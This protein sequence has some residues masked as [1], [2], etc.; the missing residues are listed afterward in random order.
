MSPLRPIRAISASAFR[1]GLDVTARRSSPLVT[2][3]RFSPIR[4]TTSAMVPR[5]TISRRSTQSGSP[6]RS[7][8]AW[9]SLKATPTPARFW[10]GYAASRRLGLTTATAEGRTSGTS[11]WSV[12]ITRRPI[13]RAR[14]ISSWAL[15]PQST[16]IR[17]SMPSEAACS[18]ASWL[19]PYPSTRRSGI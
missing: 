2:R 19:T 5:A 1:P 8:I 17:R 3:T 16:V 14:S 6:I 9:A 4:G 18:R 13:S 11:W 12:T 15:M 7:E 10:K